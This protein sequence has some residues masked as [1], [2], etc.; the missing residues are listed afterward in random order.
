MNSEASGHFQPPP[1]LNQEEYPFQPRH[2][3]VPGGRMSYVDEGRGE[4]IVFIHGVPTWS[5]NYRHLI[6]HFSSTHRC[7]AMDHLGFGLSAKPPVACPPQEHS[8]NIER[9]INT[10][11]LRGVTLVLHDWGGPL[12]MSYAVRHPDNVR[13]LVIFNTWCW[14]SNVDRR[15]D[16]VARVLASPVYRLLENRLNFTARM[17]IPN[18]MGTRSRLTPEIHRHYIEPLRRREDRACQ[19]EMIRGIRHSSPWLGDLWSQRAMLKDIPAIIMWGMKDRAFS[20]RDLGR[21]KDALTGAE[22]QELA[23]AG[24]FPQ[25]ECPETV[26]L[27]L[28]RFLN[29]SS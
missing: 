24:H 18:V 21:W 29:A 6:R 2:L 15:S 22:V 10:L 3:D 9:L 28:E 25:E 17:F 27:H 23:N 5:F 7:V 1:W 26:C 14:P 11:D 16:I 13:R 20:R 8:D 19:W 12:G 4:P